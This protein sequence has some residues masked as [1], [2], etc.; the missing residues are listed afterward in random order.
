M[1]A[2]SYF[3]KNLAVLLLLCVIAAVVV[4][5]FFTR[6]LYGV[7]PGYNRSAVTQSDSCAVSTED[8]LYITGCNSTL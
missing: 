2:A 7:L 6:A 5:E 8:E 4:G 1:V 3:R